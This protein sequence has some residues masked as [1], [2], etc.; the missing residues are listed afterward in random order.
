MTDT[1]IQAPVSVMPLD[2]QV[3]H[4]AC[5]R[6][7]GLT[8][9]EI[10]AKTGLC[11]ATVGNRLKDDEAR[12]ILNDATR[13]HITSLPV[14][15][16]RHDELVASDDEAIAMKAVES[17]YKVVGLLAAHAPNVYINK[18]LINQGTI[19]ADPGIAGILT[20]AIESQLDVIDVE[21]GED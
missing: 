10:Q 12:A 9:R 13:Y 1:A 17:R 4:I 16:Q 15:I 5:L 2:K 3:K 20:S 18:L 14:A 7:Q 6:A 11:P 21:D 8:Y 19:A